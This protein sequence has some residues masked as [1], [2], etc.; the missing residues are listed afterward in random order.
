[1]TRD[2]AEETARLVQQQGTR[3]HLVSGDLSQLANIRKLFDETTRV[4]GKVDIV[5]HNA[6]RSVKKPLATDSLLLAKVEKSH[7]HA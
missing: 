1:M 6:G 7:F 4:F 3:A 2:Q 5:V